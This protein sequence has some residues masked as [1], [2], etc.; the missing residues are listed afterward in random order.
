[1]IKLLAFAAFAT[2]TY[3]YLFHAD[4]MEFVN[5]C[6]GLHYLGLALATLVARA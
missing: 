6:L 4:N 1:M 3:A 2:P 5:L